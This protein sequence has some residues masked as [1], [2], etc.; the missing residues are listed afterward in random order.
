M[1]PRNWR[2]YYSYRPPSL[3]A[4]GK[5]SDDQ[6]RTQ[7]RAYI[8]WLAQARK[9]SDKGAENYARAQP[10]CGAIVATLQ[11]ESHARQCEWIAEGCIIR[12]VRCWSGGQHFGLYPSYCDDE[13]FQARWE[14]LRKPDAPTTYSVIIEG[15]FTNS[16]LSRSRAREWALAELNRR[17]SGRTMDQLA[18]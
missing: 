7:E 17:R 14:R 18:A 6:V 11:R 3:A 2:T 9:W 15:H 12:A 5:L 8:A 10:V 16:F 13:K 1:K 4:L